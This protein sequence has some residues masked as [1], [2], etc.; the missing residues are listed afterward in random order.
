MVNSVLYDQLT[1]GGILKSPKI[2]SKQHEL[3]AVNRRTTIPD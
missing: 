1:V 3:Q 2:R